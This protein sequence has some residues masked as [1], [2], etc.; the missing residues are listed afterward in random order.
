MASKLPAVFFGALLS[1]AALTFTPT[2]QHYTKLLL[3]NLTK[4]K[5]ALPASFNLPSA[6]Q[7]HHQAGGAGAFAGC[8]QFFFEGVP[9]QVDHAE[10][11]Q[12]RAL[13][14][15][16]FAVYHSG[17]S[18]TPLFVAERLNKA[19]LLDA[20]DEQRTNRF[21]AEARLPSAKRANL[22]DYK[23]SGYDRGHMAPAGD[24]PTPEAMAQ[25]FSLAN[26]VPQAPENNR[27]VWAKSVEKAVRKYVMRAG[28]DVY[29]ITGP[30]FSQHHS[31]DPN[32]QRVWVPDALYKLVYDP[33]T[34][35]SWAYWVENRGDAKL[36][37]VISYQTLVERTGLKLLPAL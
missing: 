32:M 20:Q 1:A 7:G 9:P 23:G 4:A 29:V 26:M 31:A 34:N 3:S 8:P 33:A 13:C 24:M 28:G 21:Y 16:A 10:R 12:P 36:D 37:G 5:A 30:V 18:H 15:S 2:G 35:K 22:E 19:Q 27:G 11:W 17:A 6:G 25:S 14:F